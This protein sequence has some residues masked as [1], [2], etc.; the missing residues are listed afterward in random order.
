MARWIVAIL[1]WSSIA[2]A[3]DEIAVDDRS[4]PLLVVIGASYA[5]DWGTPQIPGYTVRNA[6]AGGEETK[7]ML[8]RFDRDVVDA[9]ADIVLIWGHINN[10]HRAPG[11]DYAVAEEGA[12]ADYRAMIAKAR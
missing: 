8:A 10:I 2:C 1:A 6:G 11:G 5:A 9:R 12:K 4:Q 7:D 3:Q